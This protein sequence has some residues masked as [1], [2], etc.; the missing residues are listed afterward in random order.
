MERV[1]IWVAISFCILFL[2]GCVSPF[3]PDIH[4]RRL[5]TGE[6]HRSF[7]IVDL[8][9][10]GRDEL[11]TTGQLPEGRNQSVLIKSL[12]GRAVAQIAFDGDVQGVRF[13]D[14]TQDGR[15]EIIVPVRVRDSLFYNVVSASG[16]RLRRFFA[17]S[18]GAGGG[19]GDRRDWDIRGPYI[20]SADI[21]GDGQ[22]EIISFY[23]TGFA[24]QPRGVWVHSYPDGEL[25]GHVQI[26]ALPD[27][28]TY[29]GDPDG[30]DR[31]EWLFASLATNNGATGAG[32]TDARAYVGSIEVTASPRVEWV[33]EMGETFS[34]AELRH[35]DIDGDEAV[36]VLAFRRPRE[37]RRTVSALQHI[38]PTTGDVQRRLD[39][40]TLIR[41]VRVG[42]ID[43]D[44]RDETIV[45]D[46]AGTVRV[47]DESLD[48]THRRQ[49]DVRVEDIQVVPDL[50]GDGQE[51]LVLQ[52]E[53]GAL[54]LAGDLSTV[55]A[56][57]V[58]GPWSVLRTGVNRSPQIAVRTPNGQMVRA[59]IEEN[60]WWWLYRY[61]PVTGLLLGFG[62]L[63]VGS[64]I[65]V[66]RYQSFRV[67]EAIREQVVSQSNRDWLLLHPQKGIEA[68]SAGAA[69]VLGL[70]E[71]SVDRDTLR[72]ERPELEQCID[73]LRTTTAGPQDHT[74][75]VD[76][77]SVSVTFVPL[78]IFRRGRPYWLVWL[79]PETPK[80]HEYRAQGLMAQR[81]AHDLKNPL[82][83]I[84]LT[85]QRMQMAYRE[86]DGDLAGTLDEYTE[87]IEDRI[88]SLRRMTTNVLKFVGKEEVRRTRTNLNSFLDDLCDTVETNLPPDI[89]L[90]RD[91]DSSLPSVPVDRDQM[92]S[93]IENLVTNGVEAMPDGGRLTIATR[94]ARDLCLDGDAARDYLV[95]EVQ[96]TGVGMTMSE[97]ERI[98]EP[99][100]STRD[101][102]GL[103]MALVRKVIDAHKGDIE[104]ESEPDVGTSI[105][106][107]LPVEHADEPA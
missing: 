83:S 22:K 13:Q 72:R 59:R 67:R 89:E 49:F 62:A 71:T 97:R 79:D 69:D 87:R 9:G 52:T 12:E 35:G 96:D 86:T 76:G 99:G 101:D 105:T 88:A 74:I 45:L 36:E 47:L 14:L 75:S 11:V 38:D 24:R 58:E 42:G 73:E 33:R 70:N 2:S 66:R 84:L 5:V 15:L 106:L 104:V 30:D 8:D 41:Q 26:G 100:F 107:Y 16:R 48:V 54:W 93:V 103:G 37:G 102:T 77:Q 94:L 23:K 50:D 27:A 18:A 7:Q 91:F 4:P 78:E 25:L 28:D 80:E 3:D 68:T 81:V 55:A 63:L 34:G 61:G 17:V 10:N 65:A 31:T 95:V 44:A 21:T 43:R 6:Q 64:V 20:R 85:L 19:S 32:M 60:H 98:F 53:N 1:R 90:E 46:D 92:Q 39:P 57:P 40:I 29:F 51:D 56:T 82:T